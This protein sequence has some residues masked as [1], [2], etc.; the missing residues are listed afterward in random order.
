MSSWS[1]PIG[2]L[3]SIASQY[4]GTSAAKKLAL[5]AE[6]AQRSLDK[7][8]EVSMLHEMLCLLRAYPD[9]AEVLGQVEDMLLGFPARQDLHEH[10]EELADTGI[11]GTPIDY[12]FYWPTAQWLT[13]R[14]PEQL[15]IDWSALETEAQL[16]RMLSQ[17][18]LYSET[19]ALDGLGYP[20]QDWVQRLKGEH[21]TDAAFIVRRT[22][23]L[24]LS[25]HLREALYDNL[26]L[27]M[28]LEH[29]G[30]SPSRSRAK[31][32]WRRTVFLS[33]SRKRTRPSIKRAARRAPL[34]V[35]KVSAREGEKLVDLAR[36]AMI[37]RARDLDAIAHAEPRDVRLVDCG[38]GLSYVA[39]GVRPE[40]RVLLESIYVFLALHNGVPIGYFQAATF[41]GASDLNFNIFD[42]FRGA[43]SADVYARGVAMVCH[44]LGSTVL[45]VDSYQ[46]GADNPEALRSGAFWFYYKLG[47][48]PEDPDVRAVLR[49]E[50]A[51]MKRDPS[52]RSSIATLKQLAAHPLYLHLERNPD[53]GKLSYTA[54]IG[55][56]VANHIASRFGSDRERAQATC[57]RQA[58]RLLGVSSL[59]DFKANERMAWQRWS[60]LVTILPGLTD[61]SAAEKRALVAVIKAK[62]GRRESDYARRA[63]KHQALR[64]ALISLA[65]S[66][67]L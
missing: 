36:E 56:A 66:Q 61:W 52:H 62:G 27:P 49:G 25:E 31:Y 53:P 2:E 15:H 20:V 54:D 65:T 59:S 16:E 32:A 12:N 33:K 3:V 6:L 64:G 55:M 23:A 63:D 24:S 47:Y 5:L 4:G 19:P 48:R 45:A 10:R 28:R 8:R 42:P 35:R 58:A 46:L 13:R 40:R 37:T 60:P 21:E 1:K 50:R 51:A 44:L 22:A 57:S 30:D 14:W 67:D 18:V 9:N 29:G 34:E 38:D 26:D 17:M 7:A 41:L 11:A 43:G 39:L